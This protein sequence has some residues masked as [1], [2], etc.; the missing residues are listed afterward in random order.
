M[1]AN[2]LPS[3]IQWG[4][5]FLSTLG[6]GPAEIGTISHCQLSAEVSRKTFSKEETSN[7]IREGLQGG[8]MKLLFWK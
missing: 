3:T 4:S 5:I 2:G 7:N 1:F 6:I 8:T